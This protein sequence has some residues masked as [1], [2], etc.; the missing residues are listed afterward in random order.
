MGKSPAHIRSSL[1]KRQQQYLLRELN[2]Y[3]NGTDFISNDYLGFV[4]NGH[5]QKQFELMFGDHVFKSGSTGSRLISG[6]SH[7]KQQTETIIAAEH[8]AE[9]ALMFNSGYDANVG[10]LSSVP[11]KQ[12]LILSDEL[13]HA[14]LHD[15]MRLSFATSYKFRHNDVE[16]LSEL[17]ERHAGKFENIYVVVESVYS[18][19]GDE[20]PLLNIV[21]LIQY[22]DHVFLIVDEA[23]A[24]GVLGN[25]GKGL[26][27]ELGIG[28]KCFAR[29]YTY[30]KAMGC[31]GAA[32]LGNSELI[33]YLVNYARSFI[34]TTALP[35]ASFAKIRA[36]YELL[37]NKSLQQ[38]LNENITYFSQLMPADKLF[39]QSRSAI[40]CMLV[41]DAAKADEIQHRM[42]Q[43]HIL[44]KAVKTPTVKAGTERIRFCIH[45]FNTKEEMNKVMEVLKHD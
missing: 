19:D 16:H 45:A 33:H 32:V 9:K 13:I 30:G 20:A 40:Q 31:H 11:Q 4:K 25:N 26:C 35:D 44:C 12:D 41:N 1:E 23:H 37:K 43:S 14:S 7:F 29:L 34:Y 24:L 38:E 21:N 39:I 10:L 2:V 5:L 27:E 15:G 22:Y 28:E 36:A 6:H 8:K 17:L 42:Q 18:M 3:E